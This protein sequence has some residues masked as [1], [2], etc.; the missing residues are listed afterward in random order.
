MEP[1]QVSPAKQSITSKK[2]LFLVGGLVIITVIAAGVLIYQAQ[3]QAADNLS[4]NSGE[5]TIQPSG[6]VPATIKVKKGQ[7]I[8]WTNQDTAEHAVIISDESSDTDA[9]EPLQTGDSFSY[10]Y[11]TAGTYYYHDQSNDATFKGS[12]VVE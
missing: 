7:P 8:T 11:D 10:S 4:R 2:W 1:A 9:N 5:V 6:F 12:V 3:Q